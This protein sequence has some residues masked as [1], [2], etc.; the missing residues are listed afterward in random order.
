MQNQL[1]SPAYARTRKLYMAQA[2]I[3]YLV[4]ILVTGSFLAR[5]TSELGI[6]DSLTGI[7]SAFVS[8]GCVFEL[9]SLFYRKKTVKRFVVILTVLNQALFTFLY[10]I[11]LL[12]LP[13]TVKI[14]LLV[15][16]IFA[17]YVAYYA[18]H[19]KKIN[20]LM[21]AVEDE[22]RGRFTANKEII[23]LVTGIL[24]SFGM[25]W[26]IDTFKE[27]G[28]LRKAFLLTAVTVLV[29]SALNLLTMIFAVEKP[30]EDTVEQGNVLAG[31]KQV[32]RDK[33]VLS[34]A[35]VFVLWDMASYAST[36]FYGTYQ[37]KELGFSQTFI[38]AL[39][40]AGSLV[41]ILVENFWGRYADK[42]SFAAMLRICL[43]FSL[44]G[45]I[46][47]SLATPATG[48]I[49]FALYYILDGIA[50]GG[51]NS[52]VI[53]LIFDYV[54]V[55]K[56]ADSLALSSAVAG[57]FGFLT[58]LAISPLVTHIQNAGNRFLGL[59]L[60]AQQVTSLLGALFIGLCILYIRF[61]VMK[62]KRAKK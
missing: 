40:A 30:A 31:M 42:H 13:K 38:V 25:G 5:I 46:S 44:A 57:P 24:F 61:V 20:W 19:P 14:V 17:S 37:I 11:P 33:N 39:T 59:P 45:Y 55:E 32:F 18:A 10:V 60:Y 48:K 3:E 29:L 49:C 58:V 26:L 7:I 56:R 52:A 16:S 62:L 50:M 1:R 41:R 6:S 22:K 4:S 21:S 47:A 23:S 2:A 34:I 54:P 36:S 8:L 12:E 27:A 28:D 53:N 15:A 35:L 43:F 51:A 9:L